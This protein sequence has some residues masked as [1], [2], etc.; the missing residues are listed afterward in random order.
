VIASLMGNVAGLRNDGSVLLAVGPVTLELQLPPSQASELSAGEEVELF[1]H[2]YF[3]S[4][5]DALRLYGFTSPS[6]RDLFALLIT[7]S[8]VGPKVALALLELGVGGLV[9]A[10]Q[11]ED[12]RT[13]TSVSGVG[14]KLAKKVILELKDKVAK[15]FGW[16]ADERV[17]LGARPGPVGDALDAVVTLGYPRQRA[18]HAL[19]QLRREGALTEPGMDAAELL[20]RIL[21]RLMPG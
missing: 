19:V 2:L 12:E 11:S 14:P 21:V 8:G 5:A 17:A 3:S 4:A 7:A 20:R 1:T 15:G 13:L 6:A 10:V 16:M 9:E 18:E